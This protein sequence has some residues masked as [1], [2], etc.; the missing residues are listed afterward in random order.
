MSI[1]HSEKRRN[2]CSYCAKDEQSVHTSRNTLPR[3]NRSRSLNRDSGFSRYF[4][5]CKSKPA[6]VVK[7]RSPGFHLVSL[8]T[9]LSLNSRSGLTRS[10]EHN[11]PSTTPRTSFCAYGSGEEMVATDCRAISRSL[12]LWQC[13]RDSFFPDVRRRRTSG[14]INKVPHLFVRLRSLGVACCCCI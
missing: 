3:I 1:A 10:R 5:A 6:S 8:C 9:S 7:N 12:R 13:G 11:V 2:M 4:R 14:K